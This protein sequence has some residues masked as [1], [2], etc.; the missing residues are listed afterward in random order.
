MQANRPVFGM[1]VGGILK[2]PPDCCALAALSS[3]L[4]TMKYGDQLD[5]MLPIS[6]RICMIPPSGLAL[7]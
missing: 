7:I 5:G 4:A 2:V 1:S 6:L 3:T